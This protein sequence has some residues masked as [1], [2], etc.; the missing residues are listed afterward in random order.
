MT[1]IPTPTTS[2]EAIALANALNSYHE[3]KVIEAR[4]YVGSEAFE[5]FRSRME[6]ILRDGLPD[7]QLQQMVQAVVATVEILS[8]IGQPVPEPITP[9]LLVPP[10]A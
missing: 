4:D 1:D 6:E 8:Q 5:E 10:L 3:A 9:P 2:E 7:G